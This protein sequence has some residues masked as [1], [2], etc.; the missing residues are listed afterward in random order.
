M[1][2]QHA[3]DEKFRFEA[4]RTRHVSI[5][6]SQYLLCTCMTYIFINIYMYVYK[7]GIRSSI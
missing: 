6:V 7:H 2:D 3:A 1:I 5:G 4:D